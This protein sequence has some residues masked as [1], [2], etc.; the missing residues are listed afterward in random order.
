MNKLKTLIIVF[1]ITTNSFAAKIETVLVEGIG[2]TIESARNN[3]A[4]N[5]LRQVVGMY[6]V[7]ESALQNRKLIKDEVLSYSNGFISKYLQ[8]SSK[9]ED[10]LY[11]VEAKISVELGKLTQTL[12]KLKVSLKNIDNTEFKVKAKQSFSSVKDFGKMFDKIVVE[13]ILDSSAYKLKTLSIEPFD[14]DDFASRVGYTFVGSGHLDKNHKTK[15]KNGELNPFIIKFKSSLSTEYIK[16][17]NGFFEKSAKKTGVK[18]KK[19]KR[20]KKNYSKNYSTCIA[21]IKSVEKWWKKN[22]QKFSYKFSSNNN[23]IIKN[24]FSVFRNEYPILKFKLKDSNNKLIGTLTL[25][26]RLAKP[27]TVEHSESNYSSTQILRNY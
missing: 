21:L 5:A 24:K 22:A 9:K 2:I 13:P 6:T 4:K 27:D 26:G 1:L 7:S 19:G 17:V 10:G 20:E 16:S 25:Q 8:L 12:G 11:I 14:E 23:R 18:C 15:Y 3:A